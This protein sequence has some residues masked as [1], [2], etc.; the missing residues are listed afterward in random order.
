M[1][2]PKPTRRIDEAY[3]EWI[4]SLP[5]AICGRVGI[6]DPHHVNYA[7]RGGMGTKAD[8]DRAIPLCHYHHVEAHNMGR[9]TFAIKY[10]FGYEELIRHLNLSFHV[11]T[12]FLCWAF[13]PTTIILLKPPT[14]EAW[15]W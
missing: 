9:T 5:C 13:Y 3:I 14:E 10:S 8:D 2:F 6:S 12:V 7:G 4:K 15:V 1:R 11:L